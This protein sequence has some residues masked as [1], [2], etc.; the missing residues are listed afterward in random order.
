MKRR[1]TSLQSDV[2][3]AEEHAAELTDVDS[4]D[5]MPVVAAALHSQLPAIAVAMKHA[6]PDLRVAYVMTDAAVPADRRLRPRRRAL[7]RAA[8]STSPSRAATRSAAT[9]KQSRCIRRSRSRVMSPGRRRDR[10]RWV[11]ASS[12]PAHGSASR[13]SSS[14]RSSTPSLVSAA[15][16]SRACAPR[17]P[18]TRER[19][20]GVSHHALTALTV[21]CRSRVIVAL[22]AVGGD[23]RASGC[24]PTSRGAGIDTRHDDRR[25]RAARHPRT[26]VG[27]RPRRLV[28]GPARGGRPDPVPVGRGRGNPRRATDVRDRVRVTSGPNRVERMLN[29]LACLLD[30]RRPLHARRARA[31]GR[32]VSTRSGRVPPFVRARQGDLARDGRA[33][34]RRGAAERRAGLPRPARRVLPARPRTH[35]RRDR[36]AARCG[37]RGVARRRVGPRCADEAGRLDRCRDHS[38]R[39]A[40]PRARAAGACSRPSAVARRSRSSTAASRGRSSRGASRRDAVTGISSAATATATRCAPSAPIGWATTSTVGAPDSFDGARRLLTRRRRSTPSRGS[41]ARTRR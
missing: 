35:G 16:P 18:I 29:L 31:P 25:A 7:R 21:A 30:T 23:G 1:Y 10:G 24:A 4:I 37:E 15:S 28:D 33:A 17:S 6:D 11:R 34:R 39:H 3:S 13:A 26:D 19:H 41:T 27:A 14:G 38:D 2:G 22:P 5:A 40:A 20:L 12:G 32:G 8:C 36:G 9:T